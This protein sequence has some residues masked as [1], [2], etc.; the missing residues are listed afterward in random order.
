MP[1]SSQQQPS[2]QGNSEPSSSLSWLVGIRSRWL[3]LQPLQGDIT[4]ESQQI[5]HPALI[6]TISL[7]TMMLEETTK[8]L[9]ST[10]EINYLP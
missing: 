1:L 6:T 2:T 8:G 4:S 5:P 3:L 10:Q 7:G 9:K